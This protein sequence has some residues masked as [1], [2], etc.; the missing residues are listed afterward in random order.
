MQR[1]YHPGFEERALL[2]AIRAAGIQLK[3]GQKYNL[4]P[5]YS[6]FLVNFHMPNL[7]H[8]DLHDVRLM[9]ID[10]HEIFTNAMRMLFVSLA[11]AKKSWVECQTRYEKII[12]LIKNLHLMNKESEAYKSGEFYDIFN[13]AE[14]ENM[15][16]EDVVAYSESKLRYEDDLAALDYNYNKGKAEG[17]AEGR[18]EERIYSIRLM[19]SMGISP[20]VIAEKYSMQLKEVLEILK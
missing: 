4:N 19:L 18:E 16:A 11:D 1:V 8:R 5:V 6:I 2:Y 3:R 9:D 20:E 15:A 12:Y 10:T 14:L 17:R 7:S 13:E